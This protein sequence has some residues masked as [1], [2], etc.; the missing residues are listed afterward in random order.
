VFV[1][2]GLWRNGGVASVIVGSCGISERC[3]QLPSSWMVSSAACSCY[4][5]CLLTVPLLTV[6]VADYDDGCVG[7]VVV[8][9]LGD[10]DNHGTVFWFW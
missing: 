4:Y 6:A 5:C 7:I 2:L 8:V 1:M 10:V 3:W 9:G